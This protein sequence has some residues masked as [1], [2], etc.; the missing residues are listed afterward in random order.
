MF[1]SSL[2][3]SKCSSS[4]HLSSGF[5]IA[6]S[7]FF[8]DLK[9]PI[10]SENLLLKLSKFVEVKKVLTYNLLKRTF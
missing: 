1:I 6:D 9:E 8:R 10:L 7:L 2:A 3:S 4:E 5:F